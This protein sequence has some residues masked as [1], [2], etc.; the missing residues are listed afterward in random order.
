MSEGRVDVSVLVPAKD[1]AENLPEFVR[2]CAEALGPAP[3]SSEVIVVDDGS[4]DE[5]ASVLSDLRERYPFPRRATSPGGT[6]S[7]SIP[8]TCS[9]CRRICPPW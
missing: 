9:T 6:S 1:E 3:F 4:R 2:L 7:Y 5:T 8:P